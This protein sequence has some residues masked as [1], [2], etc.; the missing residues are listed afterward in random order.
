MFRSRWIALSVVLVAPLTVTCS[1]AKSVS[2]PNN[3]MKKYVAPDSSYVLYKP[4]DWKVQEQKGKDSVNIAVSDLSGLSLAEV[5]SAA[6]PTGRAD[7]LRLLAEFGRDLKA[8]HP[9]LAFSG[10]FVSSDRSKAVAMV[11]Y[12]QGGTPVQG[13]YYFDATANHLSI[14][15]YCAPEAAISARRALLVNILANLRFVNNEPAGPDQ[16]FRADTRPIQA[17][18]VRR[19]APDG[20]LSI[21]VPADWLFSAGGGKVLAGAQGGRAGFAFTSIGVLPHG[22]GYDNIAQGVI[23]APYL[24]P[25]QILPVVFT[26]LGNRNV[27]VL[28]SQQD[29]ESLQQC[30]GRCQAEDMEVAWTSPEGAACLGVFKVINTAP[31][32]ISGMW[33]T[34]LAGF[35]GPQDEFPR[36]APLLEQV[37]ASF[38]INQAYVRNYIQS[39]LANLR[40]LQAKTAQAMQ[41]LNDARRDNQLAW[42]QR[43]A[44]KDASDARWDDYRRGH[45]YWVSE[46][47]GGKIYATDTWGT[48]DTQTGAYY[49]GRDYGY[50]NFEGQNPRHPSETMREVSSYEVQQLLGGRP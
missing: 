44:R 31:Q 38:Q 33:H 7:A 48:K 2:Y 22:V 1:P 49:E 47:E 50:V 41:S 42:E 24:P 14:Q 30:F 16:P 6:N 20:S 11:K 34:I 19:Q 29:P 26:K 36:W 12:R 13:R 8:K 28:A 23:Q 46:L 43:Q 18:L 32:G 39:G 3:E 37:G 27:R 35:W 15:G 17:Q 40:R 9:D 5:Y 10:V 45:S 21:S 4:E 25:A